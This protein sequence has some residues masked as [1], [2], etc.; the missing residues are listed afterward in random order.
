MVNELGATPTASVTID[1]TPISKSR[2][3]FAWFLD[4]LVLFGCAQIGGLLIGGLIVGSLTTGGLLGWF[5]GSVYF[6]L[7][8][9]LFTGQS[10]GKRVLGLRVILAATGQPCTFKESI[11]RNILW[12][13]PIVNV[14][15]FVASAWYVL[16]DGRARHWG[17]RMAETQVVQA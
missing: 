10:I 15:M 11:S 14:V 6:L 5:L 7:R 1:A 2:R 17:D 9:G 8:D 4:R 13:I 16:R 3:F 12:V